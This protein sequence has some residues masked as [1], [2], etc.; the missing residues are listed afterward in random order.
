LHF[1]KSQRK[2]DSFVSHK[3][4]FISQFTTDIRH[5]LGDENIVVDALSRVEELQSPMDYSA[6]AASQEMDEE[7][8]ENDQHESELWLEKI[9]EAGIAMFYDT[10]M[11]K[12]RPFLIRSFGV[13]RSTA[14][15]IW[16]RDQIHGQTH[17]SGQYFWPSMRV[18][19][20]NWARACVQC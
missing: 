18:V 12:P 17:I 14:S 20:R 9:L 16:L 4:D 10:T 7:L 11:T 15:I 13:Q 6:L 1:D 19:Y 2:V 3:L 5:V 8:K